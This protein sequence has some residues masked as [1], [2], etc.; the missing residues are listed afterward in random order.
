[1]VGVLYENVVLLST[2]TLPIHLGLKMLTAPTE[3]RSNVPVLSAMSLPGNVRPPT[4]SLDP[5]EELTISPAQVAFVPPSDLACE[6]CNPIWEN[7]IA[8]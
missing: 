8:A 7:G 2:K 5:S 3:R 6:D 1:V 4:P